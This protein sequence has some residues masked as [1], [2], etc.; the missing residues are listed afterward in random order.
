MQWAIG[1][2]MEDDDYEIDIIDTWNM[3][4]T[5]T[6]PGPLPVSPPTRG[7]QARREAAFGVTCRASRTWRCGFDQ[8]RTLS[9]RDR[10]LLTNE[11]PDS[12]E[13]QPM[14][15]SDKP[16]LGV[17]VTNR[18]FFADSLV[19]EGRTQILAALEKL[20]VDAVMSHPERH[21]WALSNPGRMPGS[22]ARSSSSIRTRS[23]AFWSR[24]P[25]S[26]TRRA[27]PMPSVSPV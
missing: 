23:S 5:P 16:K 4:I 11:S 9:R 7:D 26:A 12:E 13:I 6:K 24:C 17:I 10:S 27:W 15:M 22:A 19:Q 21:R 8:E 3:T 25:T 14:N 20:G 2:P 1:L 18:N